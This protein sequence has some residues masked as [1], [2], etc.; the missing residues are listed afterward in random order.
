MDFPIEAVGGRWC[1]KIYIYP[2]GKKF[3]WGH[4][5]DDPSLECRI[6]EV[7]FQE[8]GSRSL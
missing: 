1:D 3:T 5:H 7:T 6:K 2:R 8:V 4:A